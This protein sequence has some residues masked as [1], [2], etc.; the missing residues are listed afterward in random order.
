MEGPQGP[1]EKV[2][3]AREVGLAA[4]AARNGAGGMKGVHMTEK[5]VAEVEAVRHPGFE[6]F[7]A[8]IEVPARSRRL[9]VGSRANASL[10]RPEHDRGGL[11]G[12]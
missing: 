8:T 4:D 5:H 11:R 10:D 12:G 2:A 7:V 3:H 1:S 6:D 9:P